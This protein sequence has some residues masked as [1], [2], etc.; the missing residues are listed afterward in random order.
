MS[1]LLIFFVSLG[2]IGLLE[3]VH[4]EKTEE[5]EE[6]ISSGPPKSTRALTPMERM[7][8][9]GFFEKALQASAQIKESQA[10][11]DYAEALRSLGRSM[12]FPKVQI[13]M[14]AGPSPT[15]RGNA[16]SSTTS[17][18]A[19]GVAFQSKAEWI[20]PLYTF[21]AIAKVREAAELAYE[22]EMG[23]HKREKWL[24]RQNVAK[25]FYGYQLAFELRELTRDLLE[26]LRKARVEGTKMLRSRR[27]GAPSMTDLD[28]LSVQISELEARFEEAQKFMDL[29]RLGMSIELGVYGQA[30]PRWIRAN[31]TRRDV[32]LRDLEFYRAISHQK[33][34]EY[35]ALRKEI[36]AREAFADSEKAKQFPVLF[37]GAR[38]QFAHN[39]VSEDQKSIYAQ[40]PLN[41]NSVAAGLGLKWDLFSAEQRAK[42]SMA[43]AEA[44]KTRAKNEGLLTKLDAELEKNYLELRFLLNATAQ[45]ES[46]QKSAR[47]VYTDMLA[48]FA[49]GTSSA[50]DLL[51]SLGA[52]AMAQKSYLESVFEEQQ[53]WVRLESSMGE[54]VDLAYSSS[55]SFE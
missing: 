33:R 16:L 20:Q 9:E 3:N 42:S 26:Q 53:A 50:K 6:M 14:M 40:D 1:S 44:I 45:R 24:L 49:L 46:A 13:E 8:F 5:T 35:V 38:W 39:G 11:L 47:R 7:D 43:R 25:L 18:E 19:W 28:R 21:G 54:R 32:P 2:F 31:L 36:E 34:P 41:Q 52:L 22:A 4:A 51:E 48:G 55:S 37:A 10:A 12:L 30:E 23:R 15:Y 29:A 17:Y 27:R